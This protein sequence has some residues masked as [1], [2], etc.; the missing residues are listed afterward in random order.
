MDNSIIVLA[1]N[2]QKYRRKSGLTQED[3]AKKLGVTFQAVSKWEN[4][5]ST[6]DILLL[7]ILCDLF[8]CSIDEL[9]SH[10]IQNENSCHEHPEVSWD[11]DNIIRG[12]I[13]LGRNILQAT[14]D[15]ANKF[16]FEILGDVK[17]VQSECNI[18]VAGS[19]SGGCNANGQIVVEGDVSGGCTAGGEVIVGGDVSGECNA[20]GQ[21]VCEGDLWGD[22]HC[23]GNV[24]VNGCV[25]AYDI[26]CN[27]LKC[28]FLEGEICNE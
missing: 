17:S 15:I 9:F 25:E 28:D 3:V 1:S 24:T 10:N 26:I 16:T 22:I 6:P 23:G 20:Q 13:Y 5:K 4:A 2:I 12:V 14:E 27:T 8:D 18:S 21:V 19:V 11:N 7:P